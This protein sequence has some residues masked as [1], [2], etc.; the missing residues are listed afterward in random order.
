MTW[1]GWF[2]VGWY[3]LNALGSVALVGKQRP[4]ITPGAAVILVVIYALMILGVL[5]VGTEPVS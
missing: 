5:L 3:V 1:F 2:L 4:V